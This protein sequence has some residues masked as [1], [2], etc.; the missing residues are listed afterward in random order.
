MS[1]GLRH[2]LEAKQGLEEASLG[3][4]GAEGALPRL[5]RR[6]STVVH[7]MLGKALALQKK[8]RPYLRAGSRGNF[9]TRDLLSTSSSPKIL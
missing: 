7:P 8:K 6:K 9:L 3:G 5:S 4:P 1:E 2:L